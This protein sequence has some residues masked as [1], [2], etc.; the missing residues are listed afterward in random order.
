M[1]E[2]NKIST[3]ALEQPPTSR[4]SC[5]A[6]DYQQAILDAIPATPKRKHK[7]GAKDWVAFRTDLPGSRHCWVA[8]LPNV[9]GKDWGYITDCKQRLLL[10]AAQAKRFRNYMVKLGKEDQVRLIHLTIVISW[11]PEM[12][13]PSDGWV[14]NGQRFATEREALD[15]AS[16]LL[17][18]WTQP[19][20]YRAMPSNELVNYKREDGKDVRIDAAARSSKT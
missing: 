4:S 7:A 14:P 18:R 19:T 5:Y 17:G 15:S 13:I 2:Q 16:D 10:T 12:F 3:K 1:A 6:L 8:N 11:R 20:D 9:G